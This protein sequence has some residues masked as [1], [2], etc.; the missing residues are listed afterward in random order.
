MLANQVL[1]GRRGSAEFFRIEV[2]TTRDAVNV[3]VLMGRARRLLFAF[4]FGEALLSLHGG[5]T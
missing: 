4:A 5:G 1:R 3:G 2:A